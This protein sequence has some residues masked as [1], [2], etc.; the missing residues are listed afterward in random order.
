MAESTHGVPVMVYPYQMLKDAAFGAAPIIYGEHITEGQFQ[1]ATMDL[2]LGNKMVAVPEAFTPPTHDSIEDYLKS[3]EHYPLYLNR[4]QTQH[5]DRNKLYVV[6]LV[7]SCQFPETTRMIFSP[8]SSIG[9]NDVHVRVMC[10]KYPY[11][12]R[13]PWGY[14]GPLYALI[15]S[16]SFHIGVR[17][18]LEMVQGRIKTR[19]SKRLGTDEVYQ[20]HQ[21]YGI[22]YDKAGNALVAREQIRVEDG[23][24]NFHIDL[25]R[26]VVGFRAK[27]NV[28][29]RLD[30]TAGE[31]YQPEAYWE[32]MYRHGSRLVLDP[33]E[34]YLLATQERVKIPPECCGQLVPVD[35]DL[36]EFR[37][38]Y[39]G[40]FDNGFGGAQGTHGVLEV[41]ASGV[42]F[43]LGHG[44]PVCGMQFERTFEVPTRL[45]GQGQSNY[46]EPLPSL[47][48][49]FDNRYSA[50]DLK[51]WA[52]HR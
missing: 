52:S 35:P 8:K 2:R 49:H 44:K 30:L 6:K 22:A 46:T 7:E 39:A 28:G 29:T 17:A 24:M 42:P 40:F 26:D 20:M 4:E 3:V 15:A 36:G 27:R 32:P 21:K 50:W 51:Y 31:T 5:L 48:K 38:H 43:A 10:E 14:K 47:S 37:V 1:P 11:Y 12:D 25:E 19:T 16:Q 34:F 41:R 45:Y 33:G 9:R 13:T 23:T 18:G